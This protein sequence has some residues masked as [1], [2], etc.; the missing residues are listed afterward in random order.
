MDISSRR[1]CASSLSLFVAIAIGVVVAPSARATFP[2]PNGRIAFVRSPDFGTTN[3]I[4]AMDPDGQNE[5]RLTFTGRASD[6]AWSADGRNIAFAQRTTGETSDIWVMAGNGTSKYRVTTHRASETNPTWSPNGRWLAFSSDRSGMWEIYKIRTTRPF[7]RPVRL[8]FTDPPT[9]EGDWFANTSPAWSPDGRRI[10][11]SFVIGNSIWYGGSVLSHGLMRPDGTH[12]RIGSLYT[13]AGRLLNAGGPAWGPGGAYLA[14]SHNVEYADDAP[15]NVY[16][17]VPGDAYGT[18]VT[19]YAADEASFMGTPTWSPNLG[20][21]IVFGASVSGG[22]Y[23][24]GLYRVAS[25]GTGT[26]VLIARNASAP[27]WGVAP[28]R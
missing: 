3:D 23:Q 28:M 13:Q 21:Q 11:F 12:L 15:T 16:R 14:W 24:G 20:K 25:N 4:W 7:G 2:G 19:H 27:D 9:G 22:P 5:T 6:P 26:P 1:L 18:E 10:A 17:S 8:T